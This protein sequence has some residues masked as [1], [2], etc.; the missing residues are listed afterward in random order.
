[1]N[2]QTLSKNDLSDIL[3]FSKG[4]L[5]ILKG[6]KVFVTGGTGF[7]GKW[8]MQSLIEANQR[9]SLNLE[10]VLLLRNPEKTS[11]EQPWLKSKCVRLYQGDILN[12]EILNE[13]FNFIIH[14]ATSADARLYASSPDLMADIIVDGTKQVLRQAKQSLELG[15]KS[16]LLF[17]SSGAVYGKQSHLVTHVEENSETGP[18]VTNIGNSYAE[19]KRMAEMYC[20]FSLKKDEIHLGIARAY[21]FFG[22]YLPLDLHFAAGNFTSDILNSKT[23]I[24]KADG[25]P[26][27]SYMYPTDL[28]EWLFKILT[29][30]KNGQAYNVGSPE[31]FQIKEFANLLDQSRASIGR[32]LNPGQKGVDI[33][34]SPIPDHLRNDYVCSV[35][36]AERELGL[37]IRVD[38]KNA[39]Q[40]TLS[41]LTQDK[42][43]A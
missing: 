38:L 6:T 28:V 42:K 1:M 22:P 3:E 37:K 9:L 13:K 32:T 2:Q 11:I 19:A 34:G 20:Q 15:Q 4:S 17:V 36:K 31:R 10:I 24:I 18:D 25:S 5:Q 26:Y 8:I 12:F 40:R 43:D 41:W 30:V 21:A 35:K 16:Q 7:F 29:E 23:I 39:T 14:A 33:Q 27:R